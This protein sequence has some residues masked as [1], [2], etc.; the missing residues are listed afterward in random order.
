MPETI[1]GMASAL[2]SF[3]NLSDAV[4]PRLVR[5]A[6]NAAL[7]P[8]LKAARNA[9][10][11]GS[12]PHKSYKGRTLPPGYLSRKGIKKSTRKSRTG[13]KVFGKIAATAEGFYGSF[14]EYGTKNIDA[15]PFFFKAIDSVQDEMERRYFEKMN[16]AIQKEFRK[17]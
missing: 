11:V 3:K 5:N 2:R 7:T 17:R 14:K 4:K 10:P 9:A 1:Q 12:K 16:E 8:G 15:N 13:N 6:L